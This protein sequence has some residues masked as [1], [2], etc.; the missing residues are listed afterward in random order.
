MDKK[1]PYCNNEM[2]LGYIQC[3]DGVSWT[4]EKTPVAALSFLSS[5]AV[6]LA[7]GGG[8]LSGAVI[9][10]YRCPSCKK[11]IIDYAHEDE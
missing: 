2:E 1:C 7:S 10:A 9:E 6:I 11:I 5:S 4:K 8:P 3:R